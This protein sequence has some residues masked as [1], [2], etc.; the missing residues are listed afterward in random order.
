MTDEAIWYSTDAGM[1]RQSFDAVGLPETV[2][3]AQGEC[4][5]AS[6]H[7]LACWKDLELV[8]L[9]GNARLLSTT[10]LPEACAHGVDGAGAIAFIDGT[11]ALRCGPA[12][13]L[14]LAG[15]TLQ[16]VKGLPLVD[17]AHRLVAGVE[18]GGVARILVSDNGMGTTLLGLDGKA[19]WH[20]TQKGSRVGLAPR[21]QAYFVVAGVPHWHVVFLNLASGDERGRVPLN[22]TINSRLGVLGDELRGRGVARLGL[23]ITLSAE[24]TPAIDELAHPDGLLDDAD[25]YGVGA[26][27]ISA[28]RN[29]AHTTI[30]SR[31]G[32]VLLETFVVGAGAYVRAADGTFACRGAGCEVLRC[33]VDGESRPIDDV[34]CVSLRHQSWDLATLGVR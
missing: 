24:G 4:Y 12:L 27:M 33:T 28:S 13:Y 16:K 32:T 29:H 20:R 22:D 30:T 19:V 8:L 34:A 18:V 14:G 31:S 21:G 10:P 23:R 11:L 9:D 7:H 3:A 5:P 17:L 26:H 1:W 15:K 6:R 2:P 25:T